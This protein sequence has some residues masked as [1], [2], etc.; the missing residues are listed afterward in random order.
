MESGSFVDLIDPEVQEVSSISKDVLFYEGRTPTREGLVE[1]AVIDY[2]VEILQG[3][4]ADEAW[5]LD[6]P[7]AAAVF[8]FSGIHGVVD[9]AYSKEKRV[10]R[11][12][13][14]QR[15]ERLCFAAVGINSGHP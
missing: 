7:R 15:L 2:L 9:D 10:N 4:L 1:N 14:V 8:L 5:T 6:S 3:G 11:T 13:L 12:R